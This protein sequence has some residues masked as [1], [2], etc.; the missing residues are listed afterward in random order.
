M[1]YDY[2]YNYLKGIA[3]GI[4][5]IPSDVRDS[6]NNALNFLLQFKF[7]DIPIECTDLIVLELWAKGNKSPF[8][9]VVKTNEVSYNIETYDFTINDGHS[10]VANGIICHNT[11]NLPADTTVNEIKDIYEESWKTGCKGM[12]VYRDG[13]RQG[14]LIKEEQMEKED[15]F[16]R[17]NA[18]KRP[19][20]LP[21][22]IHHLQYK[23]DLYYVVVGLWDD[24]WPYEIFVG[25]NFN[26]ESDG[27]FI[28]KKTTKGI[29]KK[30]KR[31]SYILTNDQGEEF[32]ISGE[33][34]NDV[35]ES[36]TRLVSL[37]LRHG[38]DISFVVETIERSKSESMFSFSKVMSRVLKKYI[39]DG[40]KVFGKECPSCGSNGLVREGGCVSCK[41][42]GWT[43]C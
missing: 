43:A 4:D 18:T 26:N 33:L 34:H 14:V 32:P 9:H 39:L 30:L 23:G 27:L 25:K 10:Y 41:D 11:I 24:K 38:T 42:C 35:V 3:D 5:R 21:C 15:E 13:C 40:T 8:S 28:P 1:K 2:D 12:T 29:V 7:N 19:K 17:N 20:E 16:K 22:D 31:G 36:M 6:K 37:S